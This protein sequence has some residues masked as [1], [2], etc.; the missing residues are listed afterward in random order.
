MDA[1]E[2]AERKGREAAE[3]GQPES[4]CP[5]GD[6]RTWRGAV[7]FS[8]GFIRAWL[9]GHREVTGRCPHGVHHT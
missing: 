9:K 1:F 7:T 3:A 6:H 2:G 4:A 8:R 5:Y